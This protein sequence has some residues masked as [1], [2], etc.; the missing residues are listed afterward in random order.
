MTTRHSS[1]PHAAGL[2]KARKKAGNPSINKVHIAVYDRIGV[3]AMTPETLRSY[4]DP[5]HKAKTYDLVNLLALADVYG[6]KPKDISAELVEQVNASRD[7]LI[8]QL[9]CFYAPAAA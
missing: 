2:A 5:N 3:L 6:V 9:R 4:H 7:L 8:R 1:N